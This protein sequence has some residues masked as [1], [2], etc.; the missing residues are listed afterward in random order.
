[1]YIGISRYILDISARDI[2]A[3][4]ARYICG[5]CMTFMRYS[6]YITDTHANKYSICPIYIA[7]APH[8]N[9]RYTRDIYAIGDIY[10]IYM[11]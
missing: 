6:F 1:M 7:D 9:M 4:L 8:I 11:Q 3:I 10:A 5:I 2:S